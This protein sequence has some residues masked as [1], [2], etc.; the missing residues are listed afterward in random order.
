MLPVTSLGIVLAL[1]LQ[2]GS[3]W[4]SGVRCGCH[5][6]CHSSFPS[7]PSSFPTTGW[8]LFCSRPERPVIR[9]AK[10]QSLR[11]ILSKIPRGCFKFWSKGHYLFPYLEIL[12]SWGYLSISHLFVLEKKK[13]RE[14][15]VLR[16][17]G[18]CLYFLTFLWNPAKTSRRGS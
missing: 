2:V 7:S 3:P 13:K 6:P 18:K 12:I 17:L 15:C 10:L 14:P 4:H 8:L 11:W 5:L 9:D 16:V 1:L